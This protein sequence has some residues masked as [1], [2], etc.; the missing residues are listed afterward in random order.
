MFRARLANIFFLSV[1][2]IE[3]FAINIEFSKLINENDC[4]NYVFNESFAD[5]IILTNDSYIN[6]N[7]NLTNMK[8]EKIQLNFE[9]GTI[10]SLGSNTNL[11]LDNFYLNLNNTQEKVCFYFESSGSLIIKVNFF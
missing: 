1:R 8:E 3:I 2:I 11:I 6:Y 7:I 5:Q 4:S 10:Y 9:N